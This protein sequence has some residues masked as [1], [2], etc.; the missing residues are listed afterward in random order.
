MPN[1]P[2]HL[3][4]STQFLFYNM[5]S[6]LVSKAKVN[7][8]MSHTHTFH[9]KLISMFFLK[10]TMSMVKLEESRERIRTELDNIVDFWLKYSHDTVH[11]YC[12]YT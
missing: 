5:L 7:S 9:H 4:R 8:G 12:G 3:I 11:G 2:E 1:L 6:I 10:G